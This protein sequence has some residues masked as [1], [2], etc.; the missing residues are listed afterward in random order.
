M[1]K[2]KTSIVLHMPTGRM[3]YFVVRGIA[4]CT[5]DCIL[6]LTF[7]ETQQNRFNQLVY[8]FRISL[9]NI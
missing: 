5:L 6:R 4:S 1:R 8:S 9:F 7:I 2:S 3:Y